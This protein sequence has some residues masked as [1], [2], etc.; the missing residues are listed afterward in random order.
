[1]RPVVRIGEGGSWQRLPSQCIYR[2]TVRLVEESGLGA[3]RVRRSARDRS[4]D[5]SESDGGDGDGDD[6]D[7]D[8]D[9]GR[10]EEL[11]FELAFSYCFKGGEAA[12]QGLQSRCL[13]FS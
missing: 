2:H 6:D 3:G 13:L 8:R 7:D 9:G 4:V 1:M 10:R 11:A 12:P 5:R